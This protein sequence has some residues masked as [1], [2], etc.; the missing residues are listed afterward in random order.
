MDSLEMFDFESLDF[1]GIL[2]LE[3]ETL[4][5]VDGKWEFK[6]IAQLA[7]ILVWIYKD[8]IAQKVNHNRII[9]LA[10]RIQSLAWSSSSSPSQI[11]VLFNQPDDIK[12]YWMELAAILSV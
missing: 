5:Q 11:Q 7:P 9:D 1:H 2:D 6:N 12:K 3:K 8:G 4:C 10:K